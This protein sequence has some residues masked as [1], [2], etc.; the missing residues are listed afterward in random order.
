[1]PKNPAEEPLQLP[2]LPLRIV[3][4]DEDSDDISTVTFVIEGLPDED[5]QSE[6]RD[7]VLTS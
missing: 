2:V 3:D 4:D 7:V 6:S 5:D 1:M